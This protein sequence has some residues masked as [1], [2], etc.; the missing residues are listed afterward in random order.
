MNEIFDFPQLPVSRCLFVPQFNTK[1][2]RSSFNGFEH[3]VENPGERWI[4]SYKF[5]VLTFEECKVLKAHLAHLRGPVNKTRL[6]D[7]T[8]NQQSG[9]WAGVPRVNGEGQ[10]GTILNADG[11]T[12][13]LL[14]AG[15]MDR[16]VIDEQL[17]EIRQDCYADEF[18]RTTLYFT[19]ELREPATD[20]SIIQSDVSS[21]KT[22]ARWIKPEQIQQLSGNRRLYRNITL[23]FEEA[24]T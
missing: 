18:G 21:L 3:I 5:S 10:Y 14:V 2:N 20:N 8:F 1:M 13:N 24:F 15:A 17:L 12:P 9:L 16:C 23:D 11:F 22:I 6:Y 19:N 4:V 7:T